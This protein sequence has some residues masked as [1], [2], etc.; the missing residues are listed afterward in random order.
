VV[1]LGRPDTYEDATG[2]VRLV[3]IAINSAFGGLGQ[4]DPWY[5]TQEG[6]YWRV[7][8]VSIF[9]EAS[10]GTVGTLV[11]TFQALYGGNTPANYWPASGGL[12]AAADP[13]VALNQSFLFT[14]N[15][16]VSDNY[17]NV[18]SDF[19]RV[20][21]GGLPLM[22][23][24]GGVLFTFLMSAAGG[25]DGGCT[26]HDGHMQIEQFQP[27]AVTGGQGANADLYLLPALG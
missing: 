17:S 12:V 9:G 21:V 5:E 13:N 23:L 8:Y 25:Y 3:R 26:L 16:E 18:D 6:S 15:T 11:I 22:Y 19:Q 4:T 20:W 27:G 14:W 10:G 7:R 2:T 1:D 24:P